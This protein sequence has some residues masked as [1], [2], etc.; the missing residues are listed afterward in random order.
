MRFLS[1]MSG[2][3]LV[4]AFRLL[5]RLVSARVWLAAWLPL[6][7]LALSQP[8]PGYA[9]PTPTENE[10]KAAYVFNFG[11]FVEWPPGKFAAKDSPLVIGLIGSGPVAEVIDAVIHKKNINTHPLLLKRLS[12]ADDLKPCHILF[13]CRSEAEHAAQIT[14]AVKG[15]S[16]LT[17]GESEEFLAQGGIIN[18]YVESETVKFAVNLEAAQRAQLNISSKLLAVAKI[19]KIKPS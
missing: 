15:A 17:V 9:A 4:P 8:L 2:S 10:V 1:D 13:V 14:A 5:G 3:T 12:T 7:F 19:V 18:F 6:T 11:R 16:V